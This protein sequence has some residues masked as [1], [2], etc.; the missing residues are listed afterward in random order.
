MIMKKA[1]LIIGILISFSVIAEEKIVIVDGRKILLSEDFTW[2]YIEDE[3]IEQ[4]DDPLILNKDFRLQAIYVDPKKR[5]QICLDPKIWKSVKPISHGYKAQFINA[6]DTGYGLVIFDGIELTLDQ[7][8][9]MLINNANN[10][11]S[12]AYILSTKDCI[13]NDLSGRLITYAVTTMDID[14][15]FFTFIYS[16]DLGSMQYTF[17]TANSYF[18]ELRPVFLKAISGLEFL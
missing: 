17:Y 14:L 16:S 15:V 3:E 18:E 8:Q 10:V 4:A 12:N 6:D 5:F 2:Q 7:I 13:V 9:N 1:L 11:D